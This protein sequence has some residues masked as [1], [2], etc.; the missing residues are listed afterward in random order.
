ML[1]L[2]SLFACTGPV[3]LSDTDVTGEPLDLR[4]DDS[5]IG[6]L[7]PDQIVIDG[8]EVVIEPGADVMI[9]LFGTYQGPTVGMQDVHTYQAKFG[10]HF[11]LMGTT[12]NVLDVPDGTVVDCTNE[13]AE[14]QMASLEPIGIPNGATVD[15][16]E[17]G[18]SM[19]L[20]P[21]MAVELEQGQRYV[22]QS[23]YLNSGPDPILVRDKTVLTTLA[24][25]AVETWA[26][27]LI[28]NRDDFVIP[29][30]GTA[31]TSFE[32]E[33]D[34]DLNLLYLIGHMHEWGTSFSLSRVD[35]ERSLVYDIPEWDPVYRDA[36]LVF[37]GLAEG[38]TLPAGSRFETSC[39]WANDTDHDLVFPHEMCVSVLYVFPQKTTIICDGNGQ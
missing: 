28:M 38:M 24:P 29:A 19:P 8:P 26:A 37:D 39:D 17:S 23:H 22:M 27:P 20:Q 36:P 14:F 32:C 35:G 18:L 1:T 11:Q 21:G 31:S 7:G 12:T 30:G 25:E 10:H 6:E 4:L 15:G 2:H 13:S 9:C 3:E 5:D 33:V 16:V 34:Q